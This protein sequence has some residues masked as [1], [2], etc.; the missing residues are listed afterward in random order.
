MHLLNVEKGYDTIVGS[1]RLYRAYEG[2]Q[3]GIGGTLHAGGG[4]AFGVA[5]TER[6][7]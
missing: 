4:G 6:A 3:I 1:V 2:S 7:P 5:C